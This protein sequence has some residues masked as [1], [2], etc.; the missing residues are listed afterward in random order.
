MLKRR[1]FSL[2]Y[3]FFIVVI[4][5]TSAKAGTPFSQ[6]GM[7]QN[8]QNYSGN[9]FY[10]PNNAIITAPKI[11]YA[12]G[13]SLK[14]GDCEQIVQALVENECEKRKKCQN[15]QLSDIRPNLM[16]QLSTLPNYNYA[17]S[18][19]GYIDTAFELYMKQNHNVNYVNPSAS[20]P[21][22]KARAATTKP[23]AQSAYAER[24]AEL[25]KL[26]A[27][28]SN[29]NYTV[30][31]TDFPKTIDDVSFLD[32][33]AVKTAG[34]EKYKDAQVYIPLN[35]SEEDTSGKTVI[36]ECVKVYNCIAQYGQNEI[37]AEQEY[38]NEYIKNTSLAAVTEAK[39]KLKNAT[40]SAILAPCKC[41]QNK[42][43]WKIMGIT[44]DKKFSTSA[45][46]TA[47][48]YVNGLSY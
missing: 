32:T 48:Q 1:I 15:L 46:E 16:V 6:Y 19:A 40:E 42:Q 4:S 36:S 35:I 3:V 14:A 33:I 18:C 47:Q 34:Y 2:K 20:F 17:A 24:A 9:P 45:A 12:N 31:E 22:A 7:I 37:N 11:V 10:V 39:T 29:T 5:I 13:P 44:C 25:K 30:T 27:Q 41:T 8:V 23:K 21:T 28:N 43:Y 26:Q 38:Y